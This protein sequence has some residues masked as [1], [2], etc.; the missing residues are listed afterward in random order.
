LV[1]EYFDFRKG[2][3]RPETFGSSR[4]LVDGLLTPRQVLLGGLAAFAATAAIGLVFVA[5]HGWPILLLGLIGIAGGFFYTGTPVA[6]KYLGLGDLYVFLLMGPLMVIGSFFVLTGQW[7]AEAV[8]VSLPV[9]FITAAILSANNLRDIAHDT[10]ASVKTTAGRLGHRWARLEY[11]GLVVLTYAMI[12][13][14]MA[15][16]F[17]PLWSLLTFL[18]LKPAIGMISSA[19]RSHPETPDEI[20]TLDVQTAQTHLM[21]S[22]LLIISVI[23]GTIL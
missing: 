13:I 14:L 18:T 6:F 11:S 17:L 3:D 5:V 4:V 23:L 20:A 8:W 7:A 15:A 12:P 22:V 21:F 16:K 9:G 2:V 19:L 1:S 10:K